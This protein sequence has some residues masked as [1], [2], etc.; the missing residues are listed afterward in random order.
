MASLFQIFM[1][2]ILAFAIGVCFYGWLLQRLMLWSVR[3]DGD[4]QSDWFSNS[5][6]MFCAHYRAQVGLHLVTPARWEM[7]A[8]IDGKRFVTYGETEEQVIRRMI[9]SVEKIRS[10]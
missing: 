5:L 4:S 10:E 6:T 3:R 1:L 7:Q 8:I 2:C 9:L